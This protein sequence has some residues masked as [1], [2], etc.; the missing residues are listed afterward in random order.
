MGNHNTLKVLKAKLRQE[1]GA[2]VPFACL[3][4]PAKALR[5]SAGGLLQL[6]G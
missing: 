6:T 2:E 3:Q 1:L 5:H 4:T